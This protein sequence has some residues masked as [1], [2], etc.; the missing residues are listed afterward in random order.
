MDSEFFKWLGNFALRSWFFQFVS[1]LIASV[2]ANRVFGIPYWQVVDVV[3]ALLLASIALNLFELGLRGV[4]AVQAAGPVVLFAVI[5]IMLIVALN[6]FAA[7]AGYAVYAQFF[8]LELAGKSFVYDG[9]LERVSAPLQPGLSAVQYV[10]R[11]VDPN[12]TLSTVQQGIILSIT[13][14]VSGWVIARIG[15]AFRSAA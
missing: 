1:A 7:V 2:V 3:F 9:F 10:A 4:F 12:L 6:S 13:T 14:T 5:L 11:A 8:E 15:S